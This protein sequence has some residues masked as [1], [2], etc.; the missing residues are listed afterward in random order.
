MEPD[1]KTFIKESNELIDQ[2]PNDPDFEPVFI[3]LLDQ[4]YIR[5]DQ[6]NQFFE[7]LKPKIFNIA[8]PLN[9]KFVVMADT[10]LKQIADEFIDFI[11]PPNTLIDFYILEVVQTLLKEIFLST[12]SDKRATQYLKDMKVEVVT[13]KK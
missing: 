3:S 8:L 1:L 5:K 12:F 4:K 6:K 11:Y 9:P 7:I 10:L 13:E 2:I